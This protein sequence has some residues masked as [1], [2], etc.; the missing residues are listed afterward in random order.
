VLQGSAPR[1]GTF[2]IASRPISFGALFDEGGK[3]CGKPAMVERSKAA[4]SAPPE[5]ALARR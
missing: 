4:M 2:A 5:A 3:V 1:H